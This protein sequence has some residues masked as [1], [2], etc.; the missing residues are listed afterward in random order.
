MRVFSGPGQEAGASG[1]GVPIRFTAQP[2]L[3]VVDADAH[4]LVDRWVGTE[5]AG[6]CRPALKVS[7]DGAAALLALDMPGV[8][9][10][11]PRVMVFEFDGD[12]LSS[13]SA[14]TP[15][16]STRAGLASSFYHWTSPGSPVVH[17]AF[18]GV[19]R[20][21]PG[22]SDDTFC[23]LPIEYANN[24]RPPA[25]QGTFG[26]GG[27]AVA[28]SGDGRI[29]RVRP[30]VATTYSSSTFPNQPGRPPYLTYQANSLRQVF[31]TAGSGTWA[32]DNREGI[33]G[34]WKL[35]SGFEPSEHVLAG[36][37]LSNLAVDATGRY[38]LAQSALDS[39]IYAL[40]PDGAATA[41]LAPARAH[42]VRRS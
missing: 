3:E 13:V 22:H 9:A 18:D 35:N 30:D 25:L 14:A 24:R 2:V 28:S 12:H 20:C 6:P 4:A 26:P 36:Y 7:N 34:V 33:G 37:Y 19:H 39:V 8:P 16:P 40:G 17:V 41:F 5:V 42:L 32:V 38:L 31:Q 21:S 15:T 1:N 29:F 11:V 23:A 10:T 27:L